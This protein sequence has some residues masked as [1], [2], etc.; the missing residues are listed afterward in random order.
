MLCSGSVSRQGG[1]GM[2]Q[3]HRWLMA[4]G[5]YPRVGERMF[6]SGGPSNTTPTPRSCWPVGTWCCVTA[7]RQGHERRRHNGLVA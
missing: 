1:T 6:R 3:N 2:V 5:D 7:P 4:A